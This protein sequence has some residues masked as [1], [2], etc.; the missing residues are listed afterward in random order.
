MPDTT[1]EVEPWT[2]GS[3]L[4]T[5]LK[6]DTFQ[7]GLWSNF[8]HNIGINVVK[9][10]TNLLHNWRFHL[11]TFQK[12]EIGKIL[13]QKYKSFKKIVNKKSPPLIETPLGAITP[14][15]NPS[16]SFEVW[17]HVLKFQRDLYT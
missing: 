14:G 6:L 2:V 16:L 13:K 17:N 9:D 4:D 5:I 1:A 15:L 7:F 10:L 3:N 12:L 11:E 8:W